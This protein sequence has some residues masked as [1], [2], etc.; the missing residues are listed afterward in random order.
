[1][2]DDHED[3]GAR[4][5]PMDAH[6]GARIRL[7]RTGMGMSQ[8]KLGDAIGL[9]F[10]QVQKYERGT[11]RVVASR[12]HDLSVALNVPISYFYDDLS[13][14]LADRHDGS[15]TAQAGRRA[16]GFAEQQ[17]RFG[18]EPT[19]LSRESADLVAAFE[20]VSDAAARRTVIDMVRALAG[21]K[22]D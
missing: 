9:T 18:P 16:T 12:L 22:R 19:I 13:V 4:A 2:S 10:Q 6:I 15:P 14:E 20:R 21:T 1:M 8:E 3:R 17:E 11:N 5:T 7:R